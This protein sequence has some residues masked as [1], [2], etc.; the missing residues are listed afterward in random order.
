MKL[1]S[2]TTFSPSFNP[3][4][5]CTRPCC[6]RPSLHGALLEF[7]AVERDED[8]LSLFIGLQRLVGDDERVFHSGRC[9]LH[10]G[11]HAGLQ[12]AVFVPHLDPHIQRA[13]G[14]FHAIT[15]AHDVAAKSF[16][17]ISEHGEDSPP[18]RHVTAAMSRSFTS[19]MT[20]KSVGSLIV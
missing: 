6:S 7:R 18:D 17:G 5:T 16:A 3:S 10:I 9:N 19:A 13:R 1:P 15:D 2:V 4:S 11:K 8:D 14:R 12:T 20:H